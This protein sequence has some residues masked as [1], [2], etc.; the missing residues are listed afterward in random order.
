MV[1]RLRIELRS[2]L[3][4]MRTDSHWALILNTYRRYEHKGFAIGGFQI[5]GLITDYSWARIVYTYEE[6]PD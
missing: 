3:C 5:I 6:S 2:S 1:E 4:K